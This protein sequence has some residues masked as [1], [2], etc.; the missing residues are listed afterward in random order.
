MTTIPVP[1]A[2]R[3]GVAL[4][5]LSGLSSVALLG[6]SLWLITRASAQP[7]IMYLQ[8]AIVGVRTFALG[9]AFFRYVGR[10]ASHD[11]AFRALAD[12]RVTVFDRLVARGPA[13]FAADRRGMTTPSFVREVDSL[14]DHAL[15]VVEPAWVT[16]VVMFSTTVFIATLH[17]GAGIILG[18]GLVVSTVAM[19]VIDRALA[20]HSATTL[21]PLRD[22]LTR[23][24]AT[25]IQRDAVLR[26]FDAVEDFGTR[27]AHVQRQIAR[28][29]AAPALVAALSAAIATAAMGLVSVVV[30]YAFPSSDWQ[31]FNEHVP[32]FTVVALIALSLGEFLTAIPSILESRRVVSS[33]L[34]RLNTMLATTDEP[35]R[36]NEAGDSLARVASLSL[37]SVVISP[38]PGVTVGPVSFSAMRG[39]VVVITGSSGTGKSTLANAL[40]R[41][42][43]VAAGTYAL[44]NRNVQELTA[45]SVRE[46]VGLC[47]QSPHIFAESLRHNLDFAKDTATEAELWAVLD[48]VGL[49]QWAN[50]RDG[51]DTYLGESGSLVSGGQA[52]RIAL[53]RALLAERSV[54]VLDEPTANV[55]RELAEELMSD[56]LRTTTDRIVIVLSHTPVP[57]ERKTIDV[58]LD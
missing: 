27:I 32:E 55:H 11:S 19:I 16:G 23:A 9:R 58:N 53:A 35:L 3:G 36:N 38:A 2:S 14:Q 4:M 28:A 49:T 25:R 6:V 48:R 44:N 15:R 57:R 52:Q 39:D 34:S 45:S 50:D 20:R 18:L 26:A 30:V 56:I 21:G 41:F 12:I 13:R 43:P 5:A 10:L 31:H 24:I 40:V 7:P 47:E 46:Q 1:R 42:L 22:E 8:M 54:I 17:R 33:A 37:E 29:E 51:L